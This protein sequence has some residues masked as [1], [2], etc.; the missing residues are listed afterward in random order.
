MKMAAQ[1]LNLCRFA[2]HQWLEVSLCLVM[3]L[4]LDVFSSIV[5]SAET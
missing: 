4:Y 3:E 2:M 1:E 5:G